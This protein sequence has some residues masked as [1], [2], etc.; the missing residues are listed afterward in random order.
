M[1]NG[2]V[3]LKMAR[4]Y[5]CTNQVGRAKRFLI[6]AQQYSHLHT[7]REKQ[8]ITDMIKS[9]DVVMKRETPTA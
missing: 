2:S 4:D 7:E 3:A 8:R 9:C 5:F 1:V 6:A